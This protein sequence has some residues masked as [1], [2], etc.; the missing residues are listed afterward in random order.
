MNIVSKTSVRLPRDIEK[1]LEEVVIGTFSEKSYHE[2]NIRDISSKS[3]ISLGTLY[4]YYGS[5]EE[6]LF[7]FVNRQ[8]SG[9]TE[10][11]IDHLRGMK[12]IKEK[13]RKVLWVVLDFYERQQEVGEI[14][15]ITIPEKTWMQDKTYRQKK[16]TDVWI[17]VLREGQEEGQLNPNIPVGL[18]LHLFWGLLMRS[19][20]MWVYRGKRLSLTSQ[21]DNLFDMVWNGISQA[22]R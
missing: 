15:F 2:V 8:L 12:D 10:R 6:L 11:M 20:R 19:F 21:A 4:K 17:R 13:L 3:G 22:E 1:R 16:L 9:L 14:V 5:K 18:A 7:Y